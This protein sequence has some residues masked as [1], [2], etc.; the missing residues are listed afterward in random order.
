MKRRNAAADWKVYH[1]ALGNTKHL[2]LNE[3]IA[4]ATDSSI[5]NDTTPTASVFTLGYD[6][7][8]NGNGDN[9]IAYLFA[10]VA[11]VSKVGSY[12]GT[13]SDQNID[14]GFTNGARF[15]LIKCTNTGGTNWMV[16]DSVRGIVSGSEPHLRLNSTNAESSDDQI[17]PYS[18]GFALTGND[19][20]TTGS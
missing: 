2:N 5:W 18:G 11:G 13:G 8:V 17:D 16:F 6:I 15:V 7:K 10:T 3:S 12:T 20:D 14:C 9:H 19:N 4:A 1:S